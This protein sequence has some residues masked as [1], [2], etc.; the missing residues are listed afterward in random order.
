[1]DWR[2]EV[3]KGIYLALC[4]ALGYN[5]NGNGLKKFVP[6]YTNNT[7]TPQAPRDVDV[8]YYDVRAFE[9]QDSGFDYIMLEKSLQNGIPKTKIVKTVPVTVL[10][11]FY[12]P[13]ADSESEEFWSMF[14]WDNGKE[15][16][17]AILRR[18]R[19][20]P[21]GKPDRP[22]S[23]YEVEGTYQRRRCDVRVNLAFLDVGEKQSS[24]IDT[25]PDIGF[26]F[27]T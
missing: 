9:G 25:V 14:Q 15:S 20:V 1:M 2:E 3:S 7:I 8:C 10:L 17:R 23:L 22:V 4:A 11:T 6:A 12:G 16:P 26:Q 18:K 19:I 5:P 13:K 21:I 27:Q 24:H